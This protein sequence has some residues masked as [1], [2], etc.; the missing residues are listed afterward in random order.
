MTL[1]GTARLSTASDI[2]SVL[3]AKRWPED[4]YVVLTEVPAGD[5]GRQG[6]KADLVA[7][8]AWRSRG[9]EIDAV[10]VK[11][12]MSDWRRELAAAAKADW[13]WRHAHRFWLAVPADMAA[14]VEPEVPSTWGVLACRADA[15]KV[16]RPA[17]RHEP[18]PM[19]W[20][21]MIG[22]LRCARDAGTQAIARAEAR[23]RDMGRT[24][25]ERS[26][27]QRS[28]DAG[29]RRQLQDLQA[30]VRAFEAASGLTVD[31]WD[32]GERLGRLVA[33]ANR[34]HAHP[35][36]IRQGAERAASTL[37][38]LAAD[39]RRLAQVAEVA[40]RDDGQGADG[41]GLG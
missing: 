29:L 39:V 10:E 15:V 40:A 17:P 22:L 31:R 3:C 18:E 23:G 11:V 16:A 19:T 5:P 38:R 20:P 14:K 36:D 34:A 1:T 7:L 12:A 33:F 30:Q 37:D 24:Q 25:A 28:G 4:A 27:E 8:S 13:W 35:D 2:V 21:A 9:Y 6:R 41:R 26:L 32:G